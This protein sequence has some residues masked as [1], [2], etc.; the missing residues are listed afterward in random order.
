MALYRIDRIAWEEMTMPFFQRFQQTRSVDVDFRALMKDRKVEL[1]IDMISCAMEYRL[2][3]ADTWEWS[4]ADE[5]Y[6]DLSYFYSRNSKE[7]PDER[8]VEI[9]EIMWDDEDQVEQAL[10]EKLGD[11][12]DEWDALRNCEGLPGGEESG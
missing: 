6:D 3:L 12:Y 4:D 10:R 9:V 11:V 7:D 8:V 2:G 5:H 1:L